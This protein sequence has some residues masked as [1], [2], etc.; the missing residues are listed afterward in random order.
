MVD[1]PRL[2]SA[3][4]RDKQDHYLM[5][6]NTMIA[7]QNRTMEQP[8]YKRFVAQLTPTQTAKA[9]ES[10]DRKKFEELRSMTLRGGNK[11]KV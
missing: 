4:Q 3:K 7:A 2:I 8:E 10:F 5:T 9:A 11:A 1:I 6:L